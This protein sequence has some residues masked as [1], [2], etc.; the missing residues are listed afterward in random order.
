[1]G[2]RT[3]EKR[4]VNAKGHAVINTMA[5]NLAKLKAETLDDLPADVEAQVLVKTMADTLEK[6][7]SFQHLATV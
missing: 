1:M 5:G 2:T 4:L 7:L 6:V 3:K